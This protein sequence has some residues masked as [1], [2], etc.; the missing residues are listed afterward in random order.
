MAVLY[1]INNPESLRFQRF[2]Y[3]FH[4]VRH[5]LRVI[6]TLVNKCAEFDRIWKWISKLKGLG[7]RISSSP[8]PLLRA[9]WLYLIWNR[10]IEVYA[11]ARFVMETTSVRDVCRWAGFADEICS[12]QMLESVPKENHNNATSNGSSHTS[13]GALA[14]LRKRFPKIFNKSRVRPSRRLEE[15]T[16]AWVSWEELEREGAHLAREIKLMCLEYGMPLDL[17]EL[18]QEVETMRFHA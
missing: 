2:R 3:I 17:E 1:A 10:H 9:M 11:D 12:A 18:P 7:T 6:T 13:E 5:P 15:N 8:S 16:R 4:Q 14:A